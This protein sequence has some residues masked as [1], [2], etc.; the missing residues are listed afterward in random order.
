MGKD[1]ISDEEMGQLIDLLER[2]LEVIGDAELRAS[3]PGK[4]L[5]Q[6]QAVSEAI[7]DFH[8]ERQASLSP[9]LNHFLGNCSFEKA[10]AWAKT[11]NEEH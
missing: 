10:L 8:L 6:L 1:N 5:E 2:R 11:S 4:Q 3:D 7:S 9:R